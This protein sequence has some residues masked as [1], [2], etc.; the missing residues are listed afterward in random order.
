MQFSVPEFNLST[1]KVYKI[2]IENE[3]SLIM[4]DDIMDFLELIDRVH[5]I[6]AMIIGVF[7]GKL[8]IILIFLLSFI[9]LRI[10]A[11]GVHLENK[12]ACYLFSN[13]ILII[14]LYGN[15]FYLQFISS[16]NKLTLFGLVVLIILFLNPVESIRRKYDAGGGGGRWTTDYK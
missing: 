2:I 15:K 6:A 11:G 10:Y 12:L 16:T 3:K 13:L 8:S 14:P 1:D 5:D 9:S 7:S 4:D